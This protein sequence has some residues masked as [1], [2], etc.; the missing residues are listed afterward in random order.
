MDRI[1]ELLAQGIYL[2]LK[3]EE[4][5]T[6]KERNNAKINNDEANSLTD[7]NKRDNIKA[8]NNPSSDLDDHKP[9][10]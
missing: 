10:G 2:Y 3:K 5:I 9:K 7:G 1:G 4:E 8:V 6:E